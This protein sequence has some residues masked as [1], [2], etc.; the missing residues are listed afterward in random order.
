MAIKSN[1]ENGLTDQQE[2]FCREYLVDFNATQAA[3]R[4]GYSEKSAYSQAHDL[5]KKPTVQALLKSLAEKQVERVEVRADDV[6]KEMMRMGYSDVRGLYDEKGVIKPMSEWSDDLARAV[7]SIESE[8]LFE[9]SG[10]SKTWIGYVK[11]VK[12]WSKNQAVEMLAKNQKLLTDRHEHSGPDGKPIEIKPAE[13]T[14]EQLESKLQAL[15]TL[16]IN[17]GTG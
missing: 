6:L 13:L 15:L 16:K 2:M 11:K 5:L 12:L 1:R 14:D 4:A 3:I 17:G 8:E 10:D 9:G 7:A